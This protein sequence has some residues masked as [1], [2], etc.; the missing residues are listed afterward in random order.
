LTIIYQHDLCCI[1]SIGTW[2]VHTGQT[3]T[4]TAWILNHQAIP[5]RWRIMTCTAGVHADWNVNKTTWSG[6]VDAG[7]HMIKVLC[8]CI[9]FLS[10]FVRF[11]C[12]QS[13]HRSA[14][15]VKYRKWPS[16]VPIELLY[17]NFFHAGKLY[18]QLYVQTITSIRNRNLFILA[19][20]SV[21]DRATS[22]R[23][24]FHG[25]GQAGW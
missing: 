5:I 1:F 13:E 10:I 21:L 17:G 16:G 15:P 25:P 19:L 23:K 14:I 7:H 18:M 3:E 2:Q 11:N 22:Q 8:Y 4:S 6:F 20:G 9:I 12:C 24:D